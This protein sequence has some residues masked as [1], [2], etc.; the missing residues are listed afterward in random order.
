MRP[1]NRITPAMPVGAYKTYALSQPLATHFRPATC[2]E[3]DCGPHRN[4]WATTVDEST[5][6]GQRQAHY[7]RKQS[8][9]RHVEHRDEAGLTVFTFEA[10]Q[11][12]FQADKHRV[13]LER[14]VNHYTWGGDWRATPTRHDVRPMRGEDWVDDFAN[15]Q[16]KLKTALERG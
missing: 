13:P 1:V 11:P 2:A 10:G 14:P 5:E 15:H 8:G 3:A 6:L 4:G 16:D 12:C 9:R 7:I